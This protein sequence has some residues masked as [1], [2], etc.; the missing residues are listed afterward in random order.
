[1]NP[2]VTPYCS[3]RGSNH[4]K[5]HDHLTCHSYTLQWHNLANGLFWIGLVIILGINL[6]PHKIFIHK[7]CT[8]SNHDLLWSSKSH[9]HALKIVR[10][11][12]DSLDLSSVFY[13]LYI[14]LILFFL[15]CSIKIRGTLI[16]WRCEGGKKKRSNCSASDFYNMTFRVNLLFMCVHWTTIKYPYPFRVWTLSCLNL[17]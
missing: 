1:M 7:I 3:N 11:R 9:N 16:S 17:T 6:N 5:L 13:E 12:S 4:E 10:S 14:K 2:I 15:D 8:L